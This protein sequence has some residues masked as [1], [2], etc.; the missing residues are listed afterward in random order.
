MRPFRRRTQAQE[1]VENSKTPESPAQADSEK[2]KD[3][4]NAEN[5]TKEPEAENIDGKKKKRKRRRHSKQGNKVSPEEV[6]VEQNENQVIEKIEEKNNT[7]N[8]KAIKD[9][10][11][12]TEKKKKARLA[13][14]VVGNIEPEQADEVR[15]ENP[16][17]RQEKSKYVLYV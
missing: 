9:E 1:L 13:D 3:V 2:N 7:P 10:P 16:Q 14:D 11:D 6:P 8:F 5:E 4:T 12:K 15:E 17:S